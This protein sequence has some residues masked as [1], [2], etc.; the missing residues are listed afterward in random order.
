MTL[1]AETH[2]VGSECT[3]ELE[4]S[5]EEWR[6]LSESEKDQAVSEAMADVVSIWV[7]ADG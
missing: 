1:H 7:T 5:E 6:K 2:K 4:Y 3:T